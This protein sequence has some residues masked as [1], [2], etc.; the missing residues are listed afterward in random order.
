MARI[1][2]RTGTRSINN[3]L[4]R[5]EIN[6]RTALSSP[7][8][9]GLGSLLKAFPNIAGIITGH[10][11]VWNH[12]ICPIAVCFSENHRSAEQRSA[13]TEDILERNSWMTGPRVCSRLKPVG[14][15]CCIECEQEDIRNF[16]LAY[17]HREHQIF[18]VAY[19]WRHGCRLLEYCWQPGLGLTLELPGYG[20]Y[21]LPGV[22]VD[23]P[24]TANLD[25]AVELARTFAHMLVPD[26]GIDPVDVRSRLLQAVVSCGFGYRRRLCLSRL[27]DRI[28]VVYGAEYLKHLGFSTS[29]TQAR[30]S[31]F[32][33]SAFR[34]DKRNNPVVVALLACALNEPVKSN[35]LVK[36]SNCQGSDSEVKWTRDPA[37]ETVLKSSGYILNRA[38]TTLGINRSQLIKRIIASGIRCPVAFGSN[39]KFSE[40][41]V[42]AMIAMLKEGASRTSVRGKF[43][44]TS[45]F[46]DQLAIYDL[47][48]REATRRHRFAAKCREHRA[49]VR[50]FQTKY[51]NALRMEMRRALP[52]P[53]SFLSRHDL[54]WLQQQFLKCPGSVRPMPGPSAGRGRVDDDLLDSQIAEKLRVAIDQV[55]AMQPPRMI[56][57]TLALRV[58][59]L[60]LALF[61]KL[62]ACRLPQSEAILIERTES[63]EAFTNRKLEAVFLGLAK[64]P[65]S[66][67][68]QILCRTS[69]F[70]P[71]KIRQ[72][73]RAIRLLAE[74]HGL[75]FS[76]HAAGWLVSD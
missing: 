54:I 67:T 1:V 70:L 20:R 60:S 12:T 73:R 63:P 18:P 3:L 30:A 65:R 36:N 57:T 23:V 17:W 48:L 72:H 21:S 47:E 53:I 33:S 13:W 66:L 37:L 5:M 16:G 34:L 32:F 25:M 58:A 14:L 50:Q 19:C 41:E 42:R 4:R 62:R 43:G 44:C 55:A 6:H 11:L 45:S 74:R 31:S 15:R 56:T 39:A 71:S 40:E 64:T 26:D 76:P 8:G 75:K 10:N 68:V 59:G 29:Y 27:W 61:I 24:E 69:G 9:T 49:T 2:M 28:Q 46:M 38:G 7:F 51:P 52:G 35:S 22:P